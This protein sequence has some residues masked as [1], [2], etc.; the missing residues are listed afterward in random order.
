MLYLDF[1]QHFGDHRIEVLA[2]VLARKITSILG[3]SGSRKTLLMNT[4]SGLIVPSEGSIR[5]C[6]RVLVDIESGVFI[7]PEERRIGYVFQDIRLFPHY[8]VRGNLVYAVS[9][10][11]R[12]SFDELVLTL[13]LQSIL[14]RFPS[15][16]SGGEK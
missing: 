5:I 8:S 11:M 15:S 9:A 12:D 1:S 13:G 10:L 7:P 14:D 3:V 6:D 4:I 2:E 16:L